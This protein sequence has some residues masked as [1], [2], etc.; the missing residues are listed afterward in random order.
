MVHFVSTEWT[1]D[2]LELVSV[3]NGMNRVTDLDVISLPVGELQRESIS[4]EALI[5]SPLVVISESSSDNEYAV[6]LYSLKTHTVTKK[7]RFE[8]PVLSVKATNRLIVVGLAN[9]TLEVY[10]SITLNHL[11]HIPD[12]HPVFAPGSSLIAMHLLQK[13]QNN[14]IL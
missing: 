10:S 14:P 5:Y 13:H 7:W 11:T 3:R 8:H 4:Q 2:V 9:S 6:K 1:L 12:S